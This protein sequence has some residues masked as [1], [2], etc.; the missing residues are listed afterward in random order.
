MKIL[1]SLSRI[2]IGIVFIF[3]GTVKAIDPLGSAYKFHDYFQAFNIGFL[4]SLCLPLAILLCTAEFIGGFAVLTGFRQKTGIWIV[5][6]LMAI[7]TPLTFILALTNPVS[8]CGCFGDAIHLTNWQTFGKNIILIAFAIVLYTG[9]KQVKNI[10]SAFNEWIVTTVVIFL[11]ILFSLFNL[12]YLPVIDFLPYKTG[13]RIADKMV[14]PEG[15]PVDQYETTFIYE[16]E[17]IRKEFSLSDY[18]AN[19]TLWKFIEQRSVLIKKGYQPPIHDF[20]ISR[21][22]GADLTQEILSY[23]G[24]S[25]LM[26]SKKLSEAGKNHLAEGFD[27][28]SYCAAGGIKFYILT[29]SGTDEVKKHDNG[30]QFCSA[31]ETTLKSMVRANPGFLLIK[32]GVIIGKWS[33]A[34]VPSKEW[35]RKQKSK[36]C[37]GN[38]LKILNDL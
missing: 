12:R 18:P 28:G 17:G 2:I 7:F 1:R 20:S 10:F 35:F 15:M 31:D 8:D 25:V 14:I 3:S 22:N 27:L 26:V 34:N 33:W 4:D 13:V 24:F 37:T 30:L 21:M 32:D 5:M 29:A 6:I 23:P 19:D 36:D 9:K 16:K 38:N 11:F